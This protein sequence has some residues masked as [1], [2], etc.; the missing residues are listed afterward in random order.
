MH[1]VDGQALVGARVEL[2]PRLAGRRRAEPL[3][4]ET[5]LEGRFAFEALPAGEYR[6]TA[7]HS[8]ALGAAQT[9]ELGAA[10]ADL[11]LE[12]EGA[13]RLQGSVL[14]EHELAVPFAGVRAQRVEGPNLSSREDGE[15]RYARADAYGRFEFRELEVGLYELQPYAGGHVPLD[16][17]LVLRLPQEGEL[18]LRLRREALPKPAQISGRVELLGTREAPVGFEVRGARG[19]LL[20]YEDGRFRIDG[21]APGVHE[22]VLSASGCLAIPTGPLE[23]QPGARLD[24]GIVKLELGTPL[25]VEVRDAAGDRVAGARVQLR[26]LPTAEGG[27]EGAAA[28]RLRENGR[29]RYEVLAPR[30]AWRLSVSAPGFAGHERRLEVGVRDL[31]RLAV[32]LEPN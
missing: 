16:A 23:L 12:L 4:T 1:L 26:P 29:G 10:R 18:L 3:R 8:D 20:S 17:P 13:L 25:R 5:D 27:R 19:A 30:A 11:R 9:V 24:L 31:Q 14:D 7:R 32:E 28:L 15:R 2:I 21:L 22:L 6:L